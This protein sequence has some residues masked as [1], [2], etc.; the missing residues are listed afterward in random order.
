MFDLFLCVWLL[1]LIIALKCSKRT[2]THMYICY[3]IEIYLCWGAPNMMSGHGIS[4]R[5][6]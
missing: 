2:S 1:F 4:V 5:L 6:I 3:E